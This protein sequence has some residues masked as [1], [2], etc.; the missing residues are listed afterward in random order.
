[1]VALATRHLNSSNLNHHLWQSHGRWFIACTIYPT[2]ITKERV[3]KSLHTTDVVEARKK[4]DLF[5]QNLNK[6]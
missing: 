3:R 4:R 5:F 6:N 2:P 1:M